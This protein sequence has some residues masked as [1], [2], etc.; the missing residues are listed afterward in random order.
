MTVGSLPQLVLL[1]ELNPSTLRACGGRFL[2][3][4]RVPI[5]VLDAAA[6]R[7]ARQVT[8][9]SFPQAGGGGRPDV[10]PI[11]RV[12]CPPCPCPSAGLEA[13]A[14]R[15]RRSRVGAWFRNGEAGSG[16]TM[17]R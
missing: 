10:R 14:E 17:R 4:A 15:C 1:A 12:G 9:Q 16:W 11:P 2:G 6:L 7:S 5:G 8:R 13:L 3:H